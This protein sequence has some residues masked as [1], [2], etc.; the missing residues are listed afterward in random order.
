MKEIDHRT[1]MGEVT[2]KAMRRFRDELLTEQRAGRKPAEREKI[3]RH[4]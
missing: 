4:Q 3:C 2:K 1:I